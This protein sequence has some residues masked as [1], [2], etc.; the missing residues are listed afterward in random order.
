MK[1]PQSRVL[2]LTVLFTLV[3]FVA[4]LIGIGI[5]PSLVY[6][7][8]IVKPLQQLIIATKDFANSVTSFVTMFEQ[9]KELASENAKLN[10][11]INTLNERIKLLEG[12]YY[13]NI[14]LKNELGIK[15]SSAFKLDEANVLWYSASSNTIVL[16]K[17]T[18]EGVNKNM[19]IV[20]S[21]DG[22]IVELVGVV[23]E[24]NNHTSSVL[25]STNIYF[26]VTVKNLIRGGFEVAQGNGQSLAIESYEPAIEVYP[27]DIY[28]TS[29]YGDIYPEGL[30]VG[31]VISVSSKN[32]IKRS[33][34]LE[35]QVN[36]ANLLR[37][38]VLTGNG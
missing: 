2:A 14:D 31:S 17:G 34:V 36:F 18:L 6:N 5:T 38:M 15:L 22:K 23:S 8:I 27:K 4:G 1:T 32:S 26:S 28:V 20:V 35:P 11:K 37:V 7:Y 9:N 10:D 21:P 29:G 33:I 13:E 30:I 12:Y 19:P 24:A 3:I 16:D 25:L